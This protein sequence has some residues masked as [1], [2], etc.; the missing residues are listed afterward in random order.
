MEIGKKEV[1][2]LGK[3]NLEQQIV[4]LQNQ[5]DTI[6]NQLSIQLNKLQMIRNQMQT[7]E[8]ALKSE[9]KSNKIKGDLLKQMMGQAGQFN[10]Q[11]VVA[12]NVPQEEEARGLPIIERL[13]NR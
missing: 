13:N 10:G 6:N 9:E 3:V 8:S 2:Q 1:V 4:T 11:N 12:G 5:K 7:Q